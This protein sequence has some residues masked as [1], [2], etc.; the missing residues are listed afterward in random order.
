VVPTSLEVCA[1]A[2]GQ[3]LGLEQAGFEH[4]A[5]VELDRDACQTLRTNR[6]EWRVVEGDL[7]EYSGDGL[8]RIDLLA[9]GVPCPP[10]SIAGKQLG[11][12]DDRDLF[13]EMLRLAARVRPRAILIENVKGLLDPRFNAYR[14][15]I[16]AQVEDLGYMVMGWRRLEARDFG[17]PQLRPRVAFVALDQQAARSF[18]WPIGDSRRAIT[19]GEALIDEVASNG[20]AGA[21]EWARLANDVAPTLVGGS[22]RHGGPDL[23]PTRARAAW[24]KLGV[25]GRT[26]AEAPP[27]PDHKGPVRL[28]VK[29]AAILQGFP[30]SW[31]IVGRK[32][33]AYRQVG[34]A[35][36]PPV[37]RALGGAI[38]AALV[39]AQPSQPADAIYRQERLEAAIG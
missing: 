25:D 32:T 38:S 6:P 30:T 18:V 2:G 21:R 19:V 10:F 34:N 39:G 28:T 37:A 33:T 11:A 8:G 13:P 23:G 26:L 31:T 4:A 22:R 16:A 14:E 5:L 36:P 3:A 17:V 29:M 9:G 7:R 24:S 12:A 15:H 20:W 1:G 35:F 27:Q